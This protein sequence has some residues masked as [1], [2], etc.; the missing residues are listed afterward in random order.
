[1]NESRQNV[2]TQAFSTVWCILDLGVRVECILVCV[3]VWYRGVGSINE[4]KNIVQFPS[5]DF[6]GIR[7][8]EIAFSGTFF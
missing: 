2:A 3:C 7:L 6:P 8:T 5:V 4:N 1:M